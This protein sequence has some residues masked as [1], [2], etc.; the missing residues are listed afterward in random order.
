M[1]VYNW[2]DENA[3][4]PVADEDNPLFEEFGIGQEKFRV[5][6]VEN[7]GNAQNIDIIMDAARRLK[8]NEGIE[9]VIFGKGGLEDEIKAAKTSD[10]LHL[11]SIDYETAVKATDKYDMI[12]AFKE[13]GV[14]S[15][16]YYLVESFE[17][18][19]ELINMNFDGVKEALESMLAEQPAK[20]SVSTF[21]NDSNV[22]GSKDELFALL[23]HYGYLGYDAVNQRAFIPNSEVRQ[24]LMLAIKHGD[25]PEMVKM[26]QDSERLLQRTLD[27]DVVFVPRRWRRSLWGRFCW[28][29]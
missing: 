12:K 21:G 7:L 1:R 16:W 26:I 4:R 9:F 14:P 15:P 17:S 27:G 24:E 28:L 6:Y 13:H 11:H 23:I 5:V 18:V 2:V 22:I 29:G 19:R 20:V 10:R 25:R 8:G 3:V